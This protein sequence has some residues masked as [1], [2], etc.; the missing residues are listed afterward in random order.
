MSSRWLVSAS[1]IYHSSSTLF[2]S[3]RDFNSDQN[4]QYEKLTVIHKYPILLC[5]LEKVILIIDYCQVFG[6]YWVMAQPWPWPYLWIDYSYFTVFFNFDVFST[7]INGALRGKTSIASYKWGYMNNYCSYALIFSLIQ[8]ILFISLCLL[9]YHPYDRYGKM[10]NKKLEYIVIAFILLLSYI[11]YLPANLAVFRLYYCES[12]PHV[13]SSDPRVVC[14]SI[15]HTTYLIIC[16]LLTLP[17]VVGL[18]YQ[19]YQYISSAIIYHSSLDHEKRIQVWELLH[20]FNLDEYWLENQLWLTT[21]FTKYG[22]YYY[23]SIT[24]LKLWLLFIF[25][26]LRF[27]LRLQSAMCC[28][29][30]LLFCSYYI[31]PGMIIKTEY[32]PYRNYIANIILICVFISWIAN[33][34]FGMANSFNVRNAVMVAS[35]ESIF[36]LTINSILWFIILCSCI[37]TTFISIN[38]CYDWPSMYTLHRIQHNPELL[39]KVSYW[40]DL[41]RDTI[42]IRDDF[43][44]TPIDVADINILEDAIR[45][46]RNCWLS[47]KACGSIFELAISE[48]LEELLYIHTT[49][50]PNALRKHP[51][52]DNE[53]S[54]PSSRKRIQQRYYTHAMMA[55]KKRRI[56]FK[57]LAYRFLSSIYIDNQSNQDSCRFDEE[58]AMKQIELNRIEEEKRERAKVRAE[59]RRKEIYEMR[60]QIIADHRKKVEKM[61][62]KQLFDRFTFGLFVS[63]DDKE[64][65]D[66]DDDDDY[67]DYDDGSSNFNTLLGNDGNIIDDIDDDNDNLDFDD[68]DYDGAGGDHYDDGSGGGT[69]KANAQATHNDDVQDVDN[70]GKVIQLNDSRGNN[71][72]VVSAAAANESTIDSI[73]IE[74]KFTQAMIDDAT[75]MIIKLKERTELA[76]NKHHHSKVKLLN[77]TFDQNQDIYEK[78]TRAMGE[79]SKITTMELIKETVDE[80][81]KKDL[82]EL[83]FLWDEAIQLY[84]IEEFP[85]IIIMIMMMIMRM[86]MMV[87]VTIS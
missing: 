78:T 53:Y 14:H 75:M 8:S 65:D 17:V 9:I 6:L 35:T 18:P 60:K 72:G 20:M 32:L 82:E 5:L 49:R 62:Y 66:H 68:D 28:I 33:S 40:I 44:L 36:L 23:L 13:L 76:L 70:D 80:E 46:L 87:V 56:L 15:E 16:S 81:E 51:Y 77:K 64:S 24:L 22:C 45:A 42:I 63:N 31:I 12:N 43:M 67:S 7:T 11:L 34:T 41:L 59:K 52:W 29:S 61:R 85:G 74:P 39:P 50:I 71:Y 83:Y 69:G 1:D 21:S 79:L 19:L 58:L 37:Y 48:Y 10:N 27:D 55:P 86:M 73:I 54:D 4:I 3:S 57:L 47:A 30:T 26:F 84:E 38:Y 2:V 25:I